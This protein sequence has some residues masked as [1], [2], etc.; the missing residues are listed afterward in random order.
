MSFALTT[1]QVKE[2]TKDIT[3]R[4]GW[5]NLKA[6]TLLQPVEKGM[7]LK[8]GEKV[9]KIGGLIRVISNTSAPIEGICKSDVIREGFPNFKPS[10]F[11][12]MYC[13]HNKVKPTD[14][15]NRIVF[16]YV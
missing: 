11:V 3:R 2:K 4:Q 14:Y 9:K 8:K 7:G 15:C 16:E 1:K 5:A 6:G 13:K 10:Q 12:E